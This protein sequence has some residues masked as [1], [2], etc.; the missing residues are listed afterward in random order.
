MAESSGVEFDADIPVEV[1]E[2]IAAAFAEADKARDR[3]RSLAEM[4]KKI[5]GLDDDVRFRLS[6]SVHPG[7]EIGSS[8]RAGKD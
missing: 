8:D 4:V 6:V 5:Y 3:A 2:L 7:Q 1:K